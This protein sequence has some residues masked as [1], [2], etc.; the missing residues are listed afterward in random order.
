MSVKH[1]EQKKTSRY[2]WYIF[3]I[4][5]AGYIL[6]YFHRQCPAVLAVDMMKDLNADG[7]IMGLFGALYFYPYAIMQL[8]AG[9]L[10]DSWGPRKTITLFFLI[11][12][13]GSMILGYANTVETALA[14]RLLVGI[15]VAMLFVP[16][17]KILAEW[18]AIGEFATMT[19]ILMAM[20]GI[21]SMSST[22]PLAWLSS[23]AGWRNSFLIVGAF[24]LLLSLLVWLVVRDSPEDTGQTP[25]IDREEGNK[26]DL[27]LREGLKTVLSSFRFW[28][29]GIWFFFTLAIFFSFAG[30]W[31]GPWLMHVYNLGK[32]EAGSI[33]S[34]LA[35]GM[36]IG[37]PFLSF[38][39]N[40]IFKSRK[41]I[42]LG[43]STINLVITGTLA[44]FTGELSIPALYVLCFSMGLFTSAIVV[45]AFTSNKELFPVHI[46]GTSTGLINLFPFAGGAVFQQVL[47]VILDRYSAENAFTLQG[48]EKAFLVLFACSVIAF[49]TSFFIKETFTRE[50]K[51][52]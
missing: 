52:V 35:L 39:S 22:A 7:R 42:I 33:L 48:Y 19:G 31:G 21:G 37:S 5:A 13:I 34:M 47:G 30:L 20:G 1:T 15:G 32:K 12:V 14:G 24:T 40:R 41:K 10:S 16:T 38:F 8:P 29:L 17:L 25:V 26:S 6:V 4:L 51:Q 46:A 44:F 43:A 2:R 9:L 28:V 3:W 36:I 49:V 18:F 50:R 27:T 11:A 45:I 23:F